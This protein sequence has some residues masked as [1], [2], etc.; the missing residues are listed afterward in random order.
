[1]LTVAALYQFTR[2]SDPAALQGPLLALCRAEGLGGTLLLAREGINGT[3]AGPRAGIDTVLDHIRSLPGCSGLEWTESLAETMPF[4]RMKVRL[5]HEIVTLGQPGV[6]PRAGT[7]QYV[8]PARWNALIT[9]PDV[10]LIDTRNAYEVAIGTFRTAVDP[11]IRSFRDF[12]AWWSA[13]RER[14]AG[15]KIAMF[16]TGGIRCEKSTNW[17]LG[18]GVEDVFHLKGGIL[19]YLEEVAQ[20]ESL[21]EGEC[22]VFDR[23]ISLGHGLRPGGLTSC[24]ACRRPVT[25]QS[26]ADPS[27]E[28]GVCCP[29][30]REEYTGQDRNRFRERRHQIALAKA[31]GDWHLGGA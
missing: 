31:R 3:V 18:Q 14:F 28:D 27:F 16:C 7:G 23:R 22:F 6:D 4:A 12:P 15:K 9:S 10:V 24:G 25:E 1:M 19:R 5:K 8:S 29:A 11:Q 30:C 2:F 20:A 13:N 17:L 21:W 26:R